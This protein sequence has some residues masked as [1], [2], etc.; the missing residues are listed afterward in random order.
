MKSSI[1][2]IFT[3]TACLTVGTIISSRHR[4]FRI[5]T[6]NNEC[7]VTHHPHQ[8]TGTRKMLHIAEIISTYP[9]TMLLT[10]DLLLLRWTFKGVWSANC[11]WPFRELDFNFLSQFHVFFC[12]PL[13]SWYQKKMMSAKSVCLTISKSTCRSCNAAKSAKIGKFEVQDL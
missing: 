12:S 13:G 7:V 5:F 1:L 3:T 2:W 10:S 6:T 4:Y 9:S 11:S 8:S